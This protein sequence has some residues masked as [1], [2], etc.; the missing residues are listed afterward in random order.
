MLIL[1]YLYR[2]CYPNTFNQPG[3]HRWNW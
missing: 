3:Q 1:L 2:Y